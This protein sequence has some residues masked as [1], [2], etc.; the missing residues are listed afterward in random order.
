M[1]THGDGALTQADDE[2]SEML[3]TALDYLAET[4]DKSFGF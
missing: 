3:N 4:F 2:S 1:D